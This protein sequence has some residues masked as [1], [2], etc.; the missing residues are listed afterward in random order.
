MAVVHATAGAAMNQK[1]TVD[2]SRD[3]Y[4]REHLVFT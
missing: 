2:E 1:C 3:R 4:E